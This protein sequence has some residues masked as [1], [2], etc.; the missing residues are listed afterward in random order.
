[1]PLHFFLIDRFVKYSHPENS[2]TMLGDN[3]EIF[4]CSPQFFRPKKTAPK[5]KTSAPL[6]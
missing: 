6:L 5:D 1:M 4:I 3:F 2:F